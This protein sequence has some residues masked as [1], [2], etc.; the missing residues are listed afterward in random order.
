VDHVVARFGISQRRACR[1]LG[2]HRSTQRK[3]PQTRDDEADTGWKISLDRGLDIFQMY[4]MND[5]FSLANR[6]QE[7]RGLKQFEI[8][9][10]RTTAN[11]VPQA[12]E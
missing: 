11:K 6:V 10:L 5:A 7:Q 12:A 9:Y 2:Q 1:V 4:S 8:T 3:A